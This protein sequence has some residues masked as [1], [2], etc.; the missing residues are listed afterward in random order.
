MGKRNI[1]E[2]GTEFL[3]Q[4]AAHQQLT[5]VGGEF[6]AAPGHGELGGAAEETSLGGVLSHVYLSFAHSLIIP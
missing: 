5:L 6:S 2:H 1:H 3:P 4:T